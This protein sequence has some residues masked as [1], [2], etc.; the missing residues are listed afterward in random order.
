M[1]KIDKNIPIAI[2]AK[3]FRVALN[4]MQVGDSFFIDGL[5]ATTREALFRQ[6]REQKAKG[7]EFT[8]QAQ[9]G[10]VRVWRLA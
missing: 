5:A 2:G 10:G 6:M 4:A 3:T 8:S 7:R 1:I 9:N